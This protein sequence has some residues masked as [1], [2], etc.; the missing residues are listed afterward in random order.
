MAYETERAE[1]VLA[2]THREIA[3]QWNRSPRREMPW[4]VHRRA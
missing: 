4:L 3:T 2:Y 1:R